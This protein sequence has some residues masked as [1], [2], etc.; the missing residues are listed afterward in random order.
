VDKDKIE[1]D[2]NKVVDKMQDLGHKTAATTPATFHE[3]R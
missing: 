3:N 2:K 1:V